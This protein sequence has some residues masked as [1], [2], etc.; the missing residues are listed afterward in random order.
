MKRIITA[1]FFLMI[2]SMQA[3]AQQNSKANANQFADFTI[4]IGSSQGSAALSYVHNWKLFK[5]QKW[6][7]GLGA[8]FTS[9]FGSNQYYR[10]AP[11]KL[12]SGKTG[13]GVFF[14]DDIVQNLDSVLFAKAQVNAM[15]ISLN[16][17]YHFCSKFSLGFNIDAI[18][19]SFGAN[20]K[21]SYIN[22]STTAAT[23]AK[24]TAFNLLLV[25]DNDLGSLNSELFAKYHFSQKW[26]IKAAFE[27]LFTEYKTNTKVQTTPDG[28]KN[29]RFRN[30]VSALA[31][32]VS[33]QL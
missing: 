20:K 21:G 2:L 22:G 31:V 9:Y 10:T 29:D 19:V 32:G 14:A 7:A 25:S 11:A 33:L 8:R 12:T 23:T 1:S 17:G 30:K 13:P 5:K 24:P 26:A 15:N 18:G 28:Q 4:G 27:F 6:E 16:F 3:H